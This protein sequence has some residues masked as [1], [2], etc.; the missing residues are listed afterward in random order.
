MSHIVIV[1]GERR[2]EI[3]ADAGQ[4]SDA[5]TAAE[6]LWPLTSDPATE[7]AH[8]PAGFQACVD[9]QREN[10]VLPIYDPDDP[11]ALGILRSAK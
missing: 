11:D 4:L 6:R 9:G 10:A 7:P 3:P 5:V 2:L 1:A 8:E